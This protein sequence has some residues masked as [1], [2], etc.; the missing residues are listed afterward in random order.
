MI[1][2]CDLYISECFV[3]FRCKYH[4]VQH[5]HLFIVQYYIPHHNSRRT[6]NKQIQT[7]LII[8]HHV[9]LYI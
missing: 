7:V 6:F 4:T 5:S 2:F 1:D 8:F 9:F 3:M